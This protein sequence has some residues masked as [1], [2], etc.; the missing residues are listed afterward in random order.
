MKDTQ[1]TRTRPT[2]TTRTTRPKRTIITK[3]CSNKE[4]GGCV[5]CEKKILLC[6]VE[7][8]YYVVVKKICVYM[9][10]TVSP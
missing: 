7:K 2:I 5:M 10:H 6:G 9:C 1:T 4:G 3:T 8:I